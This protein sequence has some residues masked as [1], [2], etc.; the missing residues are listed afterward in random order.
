MSKRKER[1]RVCSC[2]GRAREEATSS[3]QDGERLCRDCARLA[4][5]NQAVAPR[6]LARQLAE[7]DVPF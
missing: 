7:W 5:E 3:R 1:G 2:C 4:R 6:G